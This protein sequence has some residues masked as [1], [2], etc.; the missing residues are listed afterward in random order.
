MRCA[1]SYYYWRYRRG[2][3]IPYLIVGLVGA[4]VGGTAAAMVVLSVL[5]PDR[6]DSGPQANPGEI[7]PQDSAQAGN[8]DGSDQSGNVLT[9]GGSQAVVEVARKVGPAVVMISTLQ[10]R[11]VGGFF[12]Y[13]PIVQRSE[14]LGSGVIIDK[15]GYVLTN[16][17]VIEDATTI[18]VVLT[19]GREFE[20]KVVGSDPYTD[21]AVLKIDGKDLPVAEFGD[22]DK[23]AVG[24]LAVAIG[25]PFGFDHTVT[26]GV[27][28]AL[29]RSLERSDYQGLIL[30]NLIQTDAPINPGN[31]GGALLDE[32]GKVIGINTAIIEQAQGIGFAIP[33]NIARS[34]ADQL[35]KYGKV[36]RPYLGITEFYTIT[37]EDAQRANLPVDQGILIISILR[38]SPAHKAGLRSGDI[39]IAAQGH[40]IFDQT[41]LVDAIE[42]V[43][44]GGT[45]EMRVARQ[46]VR[47]IMTIKARIEEMP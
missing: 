2:W 3:Y 17:H 1:M 24:Q 42:E 23:V 18:G 5:G 28:S 38:G 44:I 16:A 8:G 19:D 21:L 39:I 27:I 46:G 13:G 33:S 29:G 14:G 22:S 32:N 37:P 31:S 9:H 20:A 26:A 34:V 25:N 36:R 35:I 12:A 30:E 6:G 43:G 4:I 41:D 11:V 47:D 10:E 15:E 7:A 40:P 45:L